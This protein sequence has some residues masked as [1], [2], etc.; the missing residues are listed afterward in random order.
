MRT[1]PPPLAAEFTAF[2]S[3]HLAALA[4]LVLVVPVL[5]VLGRRRR[6]SDPTDR[7]GKV[8]AV[9]LLLVTIPLQ[10]VYF[11]PD[12]LEPRHTLPI[13]LC[14]LASVV[15][16]VRAVDPPVVGGLPDLLL[17][18]DA[19]HAGDPDAR[20][21]PR[22]SGNPVFWLYWGMHL[23]TVWAAVYL[24]WGR[25]LRPDWR[26]YRFAVATTTVWAV[27][28]F[29]FN[30]ARRH[31]LRL[32]Q[33]QAGRRL[34]PRPARPVAVVRRP[35]DRHRLLCLGA[36]DVAVGEVG[37]F[38]CRMTRPGGESARVRA[39]AEPP[40]AAPTSARARARHAGSWTGSTTAT[41]WGPCRGRPARR[42]APTVDDVRC[43]PR[44][45]GCSSPPPRRHGGARAR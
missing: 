37:P 19:D 6:T 21:R 16:G 2:G 31:Q 13:Q 20:P 35:R 5:V 9:A 10:V 43:R 22:P 11:T 41:G 45:R 30:L 18:P 28:V 15:L 38:H 23:G 44:S 32:P 8:F 17:G 40:R 36:D 29:C 3:A 7:L 14:D 26:S 33:P 34:D 4:V 1:C 39:P 27:S 24:T 42:P 25:G 12:L